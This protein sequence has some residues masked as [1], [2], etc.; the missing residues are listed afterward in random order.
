M[1]V[2][3]AYFVRE[4]VSGNGIKCFTIMS[5]VVKRLG[6]LCVGLF[7]LMTLKRFVRG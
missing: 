3:V 4:S 6:V 2:S 7:E 1:P 5:T